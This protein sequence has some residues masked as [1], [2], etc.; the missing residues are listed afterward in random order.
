MAEA[1]LQGFLWIGAG[2]S[3]TPWLLAIAIWLVA[4]LPS[5]C[6]VAWCV[7]FA[8]LPAE[9]AGLAADLLLCGAGVLLA[10]WCA[11]LLQH[12]RPFMLGLSPAH[13]QH[14][15]RGSLPSA[16]ATA[17]FVLVLGSAI[18][19]PLRGLM[20]VLSGSAL[21]M[22]WARIYLGLHFPADILA[23]ALLAALLVGFQ[24]VGRWLLLPV[25]Q[26]AH[27]RPYRAPV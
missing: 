21:A 26:V 19:A 20:I 13:I 10:H 4:W 3:P 7:C 14:G 25:R 11:D 15:A 23:G 6:A 2:H 22:A 9:R 8:A 12:P 24:R 27:I 18:R 17:M 1:N 16:H 5:L